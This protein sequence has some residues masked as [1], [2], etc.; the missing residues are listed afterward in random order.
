MPFPALTAALKGIAAGFGSERVELKD[1]A[2]DPGSWNPADFQHNGFY[3]IAGALAASGPAW[4]G[5]TV[6]LNAALNH[7]VVWACNR[8]ISETLA[9]LPLVLMRQDPDARRVDTKHPL[10]RVFHNAPS[11]EMTAMTFR[12]TLTSHCVLQGNAYAEI[13]RRN[14]SG[15]AIELRPLDPGQVKPDRDKQGRLVYVIK[16]G[17]AQPRTLTIEPGKPHPIL[18]IKGLSP[19][20]M[21]GYSVIEV[22]RQS[23]GT[24]I[25]ANRNVAS[26][27]RNGGRLPYYLEHPNRFRSDAEFEQFRA[28]W[29]GT[30]AE[31]HKAPILE[32][33]IKY[34]QIGVSARDA[35][36]LET[37]LFDIHE[38]CRWF[39]VSPHLVGDLSRATFSN[40]EQLALEFEKMTLG[41]WIQRWEQEIWR[42]VFT[43]EEKN[44]GYFVKH[45][46]NAL[47]RGDFQSRMKGYSTMLQN[48]IASVN[49]VR[50]LEDL[51]AIQGGDSH[52]IQLNMQ[53]ISD[54][55]N[56]V[57][58]TAT[59][60]VRLG[61]DTSSV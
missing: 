59:A 23:I 28:K 14:G 27:Y 12:E 18:H 52:F 33:G 42:C 46:V 45:N 9:M 22:A 38:I 6:G 39:R 17:S 41:T 50:D 57:T 32:G 37:R 2:F 47:L 48:G 29:E 58:P 3:R 53:P 8:I 20:G 1:L 61:E 24:A 16:Q 4:S 5:E 30:Y 51:N 31:P 15:T 7:S 55:E 49:E 21:R 60:L 36:L 19:D 40:I 25:A 11:E 54:G 35:Q 34:N 26:F 10:Y 43:P 44:Q 56:A 13:I